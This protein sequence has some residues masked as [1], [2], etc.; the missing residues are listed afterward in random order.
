MC[1]DLVSVTVIILKI[2]NNAWKNITYYNEEASADTL[3]SSARPHVVTSSP[4]WNQIFLLAAAT[5]DFFF[6][7]CIFLCD[8]FIVLSLKSARAQGDV[9]K[10]LVLSHSQSQNSKIKKKQTSFWKNIKPRKMASPRLFDWHVSCWLIF[11]SIS[12]VVR[13]NNCLNWWCNPLIHT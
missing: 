10:L 2:R 11:L 4:R 6:P 9:S 8:Q 3:V 7:S 1:Q 5:N 12:V 13:S